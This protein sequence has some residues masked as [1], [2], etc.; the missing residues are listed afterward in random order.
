MAGIVLDAALTEEDGQDPSGFPLGHLIAVDVDGRTDQNVG[1]D[2][3]TGHEEADG[4]RAQGQHP[5]EEGHP[6]AEEGGDD[7]GRRP[8]RPPFLAPEDGQQLLV[9][10]VQS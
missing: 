7:H 4:L 6:A 8:Q 5:H 10:R 1:E 2:G 9:H 3:E